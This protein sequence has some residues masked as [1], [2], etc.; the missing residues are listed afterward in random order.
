M[1]GTFEKPDLDQAGESA[2]SDVVVV[3]NLGVVKKI[4]IITNSSPIEQ[5]PGVSRPGMIAG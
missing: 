1:I 4:G 5:F 2:K 3:G